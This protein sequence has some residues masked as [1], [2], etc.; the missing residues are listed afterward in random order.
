MAQSRISRTL[1]GVAERAGHRDSA[2]GAVRQPAGVRSPAPSGVLACRCCRSAAGFGVFESAIGAG[3]RRAGDR[4]SAAVGRFSQLHA[5]PAS[6]RGSVRPPQVCGLTITA[7]ASPSERAVWNTL[8]AYLSSETCWTGRATRPGG[9]RR[10]VDRHVQHPT[11]RRT[12]ELLRIKS[13]TPRLR[14]VLDLPNDIDQ[15]MTVSTEK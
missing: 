4:S 11:K 6:S 12:Y 15:W 5:P 14:V 13:L 10:K 7:A 1:R 2:A 9:D 8:I 3:R